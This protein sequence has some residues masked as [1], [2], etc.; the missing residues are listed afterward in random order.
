MIRARRQSAGM[1]GFT[2]IALGQ[3]VSL[4]GTGMTRFAITIYAWQITG[5]ATA[6]ALVGF[7]AFGPTVLLGVGV[8]LA[9]YLIPR[10]RDVETLL[11][12]HDAA[13]LAVAA[14]AG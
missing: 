11:P 4:L 12:D 13:P 9:G 8:G 10:V 6:L 3:L 14:A 5:E 7:F 1:A 2:V